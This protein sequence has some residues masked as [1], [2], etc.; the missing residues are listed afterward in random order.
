MNW[1]PFPAFISS[2]LISELLLR[3]F[4]W[5]GVV[6]SVGIGSLMA[7]T[8]FVFWGKGGEFAGEQPNLKSARLLLSEP[9]FW[10]M[11]TLFCLGVSSTIGVYTMIPLYLVVDHGL[12]RGFCQLSVL[13]V[14]ASDRGDHF[15]CRLGAGPIRIEEDPGL[16]FHFRVH[17]DHPDGHLPVQSG[18]GYHVRASR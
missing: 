2:P 17:G 12:D 6:A 3:F 1:R 18:D 13:S 15:F 4:T 11:G 7:G 16:G 8:A 14:K 10:I 5:H 9:S